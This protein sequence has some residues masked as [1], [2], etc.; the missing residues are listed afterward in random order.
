[1]PRMR[2]ST[3]PAD[4]P[5]NVLLCRL[6]VVEHGRRGARARRAEARVCLLR[7]D[8][9]VGDAGAVSDCHRLDRI[10]NVALLLAG[11]DR[12]HEDRL[13]PPAPP[14]GGGGGGGGG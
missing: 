8:G 4:A 2:S 13:R 6:I 3:R 12:E 14:R 7:R 11:A 5:P 10:L 1:M 9:F